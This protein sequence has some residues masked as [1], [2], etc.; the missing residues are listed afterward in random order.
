MSLKLV[1]Y[2]DDRLRIPSKTIIKFDERLRKTAIVMEKLMWKEGGIGLSPQQCG[3]TYSIIIVHD[4]TNKKTYHMCNPKI[5]NQEGQQIGTEYCLSFPSIG[6]EVKRPQKVSV[7]YQDIKGNI[8]IVVL[9]DI[10]ARCAVHEYEH[11]LGIL[12]IDDQSLKLS[13]RS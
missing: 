6:I 9:E 1:I 11:S 4:P 7:R 8:R 2:P 10:A 5:F 12:L 13:G 3:I